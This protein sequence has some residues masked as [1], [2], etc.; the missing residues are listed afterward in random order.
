MIGLRQRCGQRAG[1][2]VRHSKLEVT[3]RVC[4]LMPRLRWAQV[5]N[6]PRRQNNPSSATERLLAWNREGEDPQ[7]TQTQSLLLGRLEWKRMKTASTEAGGGPQGRR[8]RLVLGHRL[9]FVK[10]TQE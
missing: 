7:A 10:C 3:A 6:T 5:P 1:V 2:D 9:E 8:A 4:S